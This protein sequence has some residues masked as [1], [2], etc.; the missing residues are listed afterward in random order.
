MGV[1]VRQLV[2]QAGSAP[3]APPL[4]VEPAHSIVLVG[5]NNAGKS[6]AL[7][8][9]EEWCW[10]L[11]IAGKVVDRLEVDVPPSEQDLVATLTP[12]KRR[13]PVG[14][15][16]PDDG[17]WVGHYSF[18]GGQARHFAVDLAPLREYLRTGNT[19]PV[20]DVLLKLLTIRLDGR[21]RFGLTEPRD[22]G[23]LKQQP[24]NHLWQLFINDSARRIVRAATRDAFGY[25]LVVDATSMRQFVVKMSSQDPGESGER[26]LSDEGALR[27]M[28]SARPIQEFGDGVQAFGG[29]MAAIHS[30]PHS[31][32]LVDEPEAFLHP[33]LARRLGTH[34]VSAANEGTLIAATHSADFLLGCL[35]AAP[36]TTIVR[37]TYDNGVAS[38]RS[39]PGRALTTLMTDPLLRSTRSINGVFH[40]AVVVVESDSDRAFYDE[41]NRRLRERGRGIDDALFLNA[42]NW[43]TTGRIAAPLRDLGV[44]AAVVIDLDALSAASGWPALFAAMNL[45]PAQR[46]HADREL[47][48]A[49]QAFAALGTGRPHKTAGLAALA[50][51][52]R[53]RVTRFVTWLE[54]F[55]VFAVP[56]GELEQWL[57][58]VLSRQVRKS[59]WVVAML[60]A[61][62]S[63]GTAQYVRPSS[64]DV[65]KFL[66][67]IGRWASNARRAGLPQ[68]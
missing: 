39:I 52:E 23:D 22:T 50:A 18:R 15:I 2:F 29:L 57:R 11:T 67:R 33:P 14:Q 36:D 25:N 6:T 49:G 16:T 42:Q 63:P 31:V 62:G 10:N 40:R 65:W 41:V 54:R 48:F 68:T 55:G 37:L 43:Q 61:L 9:I 56:V 7:R 8:E 45:T 66:D 13:A 51:A 27:F 12:F 64:G 44:P 4:V 38:A 28:E 35:E 3:G 47:E 53:M 30:L 20:L 46:R 21:T 26:D 5:P 1:R 58:D 32:L 34:L 60:I 17:L 19:R 59:D 24:T